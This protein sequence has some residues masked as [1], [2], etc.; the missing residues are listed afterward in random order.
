MIEKIA[1]IGLGYVGLPIALAL[2]RKFPG[3]VGFD[4]D[5][6]R[7]AS[8]NKGV[9]ATGE[10]PTEIL[11][12][13][14]LRMTTQIEDLKGTT[15]FIV[16]V[17]TP[18]DSSHRPDLNPLT[19]ASELIGK[20]MTPG[21]VVVYESTVYPGVT[22]E[23]CQPILAKCSGLHPGIDFKVGY[24]PERINP[25][26]K[27]HR[28]ENVMKIVAGEDAEALER[29]SA[30]Y[31]KIIEAGIFKAPCIKVAE[32]AKVI[33][34]VQRD[35]NIALMN[36]LAIICDRLN[37]PTR[38]VLTAASTKW[39]FLSF[40]PGLVGGHCIGVDPYYLTTKAEE[41]GYHPQV[42]LA[43]RRINDQMGT[44]IAQ[45]TIK[46][47]IHNH[48]PVM[49]ARIGILGITFKEN[50]SD[51]RN[52]KVYDIIQ[53]FNE[54]GVQAL[55]HDPIA[56]SA[57]VVKEYGIKLA[58]WDE[59]KSLS[60]LILAIPHQFYLKM[61]P[62]GLLSGLIPQGIFVDLKSKFP[63]NRIRADIKHWSL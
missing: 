10:V 38:E 5:G 48:L 61:S 23:V 46:F 30:V 50:V 12:T 28:L 35:L 58:E 2:A 43:G 32:T 41:L 33:E 8:L 20:I 45:R 21:T 57:D 44:W 3:T 18:V 19:R 34:N 24:S 59:L 54:Y 4:I 6:N 47:M 9:D 25:G 63:P 14:I 13:T 56:K 39:N 51:I 27:E 1:V 11:R 52:S 53:E 49:R 26:D 36:E 62:E 7:I 60:A 29:I 31:E 37:I 16:T 55:V 42:I 22:E 15:F 40:V 17:P